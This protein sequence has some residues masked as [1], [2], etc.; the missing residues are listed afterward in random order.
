MLRA[1]HHE[2]HE[3]EAKFWILCGKLKQIIVAQA[4]QFNIGMGDRGGCSPIFFSEHAHFA[5]ESA[6][7]ERDIRLKFC[8]SFGT[9]CSKYEIPKE[10][11]QLFKVKYFLSV[12]VYLTYI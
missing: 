1:T 8:E 11:Q 3:I 12:A 5:K 7:F 10:P 9:L 6:R 2:P 4:E